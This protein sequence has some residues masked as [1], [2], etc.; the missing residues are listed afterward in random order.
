MSLPDRDS[1]HQ[2][3]PVPGT[4]RHT[5]GNQGVC[6]SLG[7][8]HVHRW[9]WPSGLYQITR[10]CRFEAPRIQD[11][12]PFLH[13][14][15]ESGRAPG[16]T[17]GSPAP[18]DRSVFLSQ[19]GLSSRGLSPASRKSGFRTSPG[20]RG[21]VHCSAG[22]RP[23]WS[24]QA[25]GG[26]RRPLAGHLPARSADLLLGAPPVSRMEPAPACCRPTLAALAE[27]VSGLPA[28]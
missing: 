1:E 16:S 5:G 28:P 14:E 9:G 27:P 6:A 18:G 24:R 19:P 17:Q 4:C 10:H 23:L 15:T 8:G 13:E 25:G 11:Q 7:S 2:G 20:G 26:P 22:Q 3:P 12:R 21:P